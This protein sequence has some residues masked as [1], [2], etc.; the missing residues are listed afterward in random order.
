VFTEQ[1]GDVRNGQIE[2]D[3]PQQQQLR[4]RQ[5][6]EQTP[7]KKRLRLSKF[8]TRN[9]RQQD[10]VTSERAESCGIC[11]EQVGPWSAVRLPCSHG[12][13][14][15]SCLERYAEARLDAGKHDVP[16]PECGAVIA[17]A[18]LRSILS[19][20]IL[21][22]LLER[23]LEQAVNS[24]S[25]MWPCPSPDCPNRVALDDGQEPRL[26]CLQ[27]GKEHCLLCHAT[28]YHS[29]RTC[30]E[31]AAASSVSSSS[32]SNNTTTSNEEASFRD[33]M[34]RTGSRQCPK[35]KMG[36][37]KEDLGRQKTQHAEC[38]KMICRNCD[39][40]FCFRCLAVL[41][42]SKTC[43]CTADNHGFINPKTGRFVLHLRKGR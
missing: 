30:Q 21:D 32:G 8:E 17:Q 1:T 18:F 2:L 28:P 29:G 27:C 10:I 6:T 5:I 42:S 41:T 43:G 24:S 39:T 7:V 19:N 26:Q 11:A 15:G 12:W 38:H 4:Q 9:T 25:T 16:C 40:R 34:K 35:C 22:R 23:S 20:T 3:T 37:T 13:Y 14:C 36:V 31:H 33:W